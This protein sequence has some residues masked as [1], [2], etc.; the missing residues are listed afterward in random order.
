MAATTGL[1]KGGTLFFS[2]LCASTFGLGC[3]QATRYFEKIEQVEQREKE[4]A[5]EP[6]ELEA[7]ATCSK[8]EYASDKDQIQNDGADEVDRGHRPILVNGKFRHE[9]EILVGPRGPPLGALSSVGPNS[10]R[11]GG[12]M[13][14]SPQGFYC[15]TPLE[16][17][18]GKGTVIVNRGWIPR[19][20]IKENV[21]WSR[22]TGNVSIVG[23]TSKTEQPRFMS[24]PHNAKEPRQLLWFDRKEIEHRTN[25]NG[26]K[27]LLLT[28]T[29]GKSE[30]NEGP[31]F[32]PTKESVGEFKV[33]PT[34]H[35]GY[36]VT[37]F[38]LSTAGIVMTRKL[39]TRGR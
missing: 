15:L 12:G 4:L 26:Q 14:S 9:N 27:P 8:G 10:G 16:R 24:P 19:S 7:G 31:P 36:A 11:S 6:V 13:A 1:S 17:D 25:T 35:A 3:W 38:G 37:W 22:P 2:S 29:I 34:T 23:V 32:K 20:Y 5:Q 33:T 18:N 28:E 30:N 39:I 21:A